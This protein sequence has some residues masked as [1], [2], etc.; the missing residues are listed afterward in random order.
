MMRDGSNKL[1]L[2]LS[3]L[4]L[5]ATPSCSSLWAQDARPALAAVLFDKGYVLQV[6][7]RRDIPEFPFSQGDLIVF[8]GLLINHDSPP[9]ELQEVLP[10]AIWFGSL[11]P[12]GEWIGADQLRIRLRSPDGTVQERIN[13]LVDNDDYLLVLGDTPPPAQMITSGKL[14]VYLRLTELLWIEDEDSSE[15][16]LQ[17]VPEGPEDMGL[18][19]SNLYLCE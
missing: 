13:W 17:L 19:R 18:V 3:I 11:Y 15:L 2:F 12:Y 1:P 9:K 6:E 4:L 8:E 7:T 14:C 16:L 5:L 10:S